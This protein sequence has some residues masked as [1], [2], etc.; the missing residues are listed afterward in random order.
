MFE[1]CESDP[2]DLRNKKVGH[3]EGKRILIKFVYSIFSFSSPNFG[4]R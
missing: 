1:I 4:F 3:H 2:F